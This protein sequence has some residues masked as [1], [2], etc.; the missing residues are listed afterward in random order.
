MESTFTGSR[1]DCG[2]G[3]GLMQFISWNGCSCRWAC[4]HGEG[5]SED[6][7]AVHKMVMNI[8]QNPTVNPADAG[9][10]VEVHILHKFSRDFYGQPVHAIA[11]GFIRCALHLYHTVSIS[12]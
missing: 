8:G 3:C 2:V 10:T 5:Y 1:V 11:C 9:I 6:D 7:T 12:L 4:L